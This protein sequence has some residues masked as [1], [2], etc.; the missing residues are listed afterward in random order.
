MNKSLLDGVKAAMDPLLAK[1]RELEQRLAKVE[2]RTKGE[3]G[4]WQHVGAWKP[5]K[6]FV[7]GDLVSHGDHVFA[8]IATT[9]KDKPGE[10]ESWTRAELS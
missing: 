7:R 9:T 1:V 5:G 8:C 4:P 2:R 6:T 3:P 10:S